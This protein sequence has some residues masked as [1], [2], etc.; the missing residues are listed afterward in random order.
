[1]KNDNGKFFVQEFSAVH[2]GG[3][4]KIGSPL[5]SVLITDKL[6]PYLNNMRHSL[7]LHEKITPGEPYYQV[8]G[9]IEL[10]S[11]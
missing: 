6:D 1:M 9:K 10:V 4:L 3:E 5:S 11:E 8:I 2:L 7:E